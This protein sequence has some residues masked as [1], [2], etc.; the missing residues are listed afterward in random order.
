MADPNILPNY[1]YR[2][3]ATAIYDAIKE[4]VATIIEHF[5]GGFDCEPAPTIVQRTQ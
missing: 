2:D 1:P 4:Y 3:D 5:Y